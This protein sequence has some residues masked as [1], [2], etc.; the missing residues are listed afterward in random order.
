MNIGEEKRD[1]LTVSELNEYIKLL[2]DNDMLLSQVAVRGEISNYKHHYTGHL[3]FSMKD[4][5]GALKCVMFASSAAKL[6]F[7]PKDGDDVVC[8]GRISV[9]PRDGSYQLY[10]SGIVPA[11]RGELFA[12]FEQLK[13]KLSAEG[14]FDT[15]RKRPLPPFPE[16]IGIVTA[17]GGAAVRDILNILGR[18]WPCAEAVIYPALVQGAGAPESLVAGMEYFAAHPVDVVIIGRGGGSVEDLFCFNDEKLARTIAASPIP[19]ISAVG[20]ETDF[21]I[22]DFVADLRA[23]TPSAAAELAV[24]D[25]SVLL[26]RINDYE[27]RIS[28]SAS[29]KLD[30]LESRLKLLGSAAVLSSPEKILDLLTDEVMG[31]ASAAESAYEA[32]LSRGKTELVKLAAGL[33]AMNPLAVLGRGYAAVEKDGAFVG[34]V[35]C[36]SAG[37]EITVRMNGGKVSATVTDT[38]S[39]ACDGEN[40]TAAEKKKK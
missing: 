7:E 19:V 29:G 27:K 4:R 40:A 11:G 10:V 8:Y 32:I 37:D 38:V 26:R 5:T 28:V 13:K 1:W 25:V 33:E 12:A 15:A 22:A 24:P 39:D 34:H 30:M 6:R 21:T 36:V 35:S 14:L 17:E 9:F 18:R 16:R 31:L 23:P 3:Y 2:L 20:H